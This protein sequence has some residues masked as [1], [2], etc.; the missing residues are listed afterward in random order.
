[1]ETK[2]MSKVKLMGIA[3]LVAG[4]TSACT[5]DQQFV[6]LER[7]VAALEKSAREETIR[8]IPPKTDPE[9]AGSAGLNQIT[10]CDTTDGKVVVGVEHE[11]NGN[12]KALCRQ[13]DILPDLPR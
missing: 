8:F 4:A 13:L 10:R 9:R 11:S 6:E 2:R 12:I 7:R 1:M 5:P 3:I